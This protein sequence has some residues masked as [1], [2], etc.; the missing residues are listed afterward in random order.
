MK[1]I[2]QK[3]VQ[4]CPDSGKTLHGR[5]VVQLQLAELA[6]SFIVNWK[7]SDVSTTDWMV[8][9]LQAAWY[10]RRVRWTC[11]FYIS[12]IFWCLWTKPTIFLLL[13]T[14]PKRS[15]FHIS[16]SLYWCFSS[17]PHSLQKPLYQVLHW[18]CCGSTAVGAGGGHIPHERGF[19]NSPYSF[20]ETPTNN[21][22]GHR[23]QIH[24]TRGREPIRGW[25]SKQFVEFQL[26][27]ALVVT[28]SHT[29]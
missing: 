2:A 29:W 22:S 9:T 24:A 4:Y 26:K 21:G 16:Q 28:R 18:M 23:L 10:I 20:Y 7:T 19:K 15:L 11:L 13:P 1:I 5:T 8:E 27:I 6:R 3:E 14:P 12:F 25:Y 17:F